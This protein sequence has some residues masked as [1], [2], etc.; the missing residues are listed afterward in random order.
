MA[1]NDAEQAA[2]PAEKKSDKLKA[3]IVLVAVLLLEGG[4]I[5]I[6][7]RLTGPK[8]VT[9]MEVA[10]EQEDPAKQIIEQLVVEM[11][12]PNMKTGKTYLYDFT[13]VATFKQEDLDAVQERLLKREH[14]INDRLRTIIA[15]SDPKDLKEPGLEILRRQIKVELE[16]I[17]DSKDII[18]E[19]LIPKCTPL[20]TDV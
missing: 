4:T 3:I 13:V 16:T 8:A 15:I 17:L 2:A 11:R 12:A 6:T 20:R 14:M 10:E 5:F 9:G 19:V 1:E 18:Q 7:M